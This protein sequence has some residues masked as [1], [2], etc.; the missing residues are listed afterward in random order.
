MAQHPESAPH[1]EPA[2]RT[3]PARATFSTEHFAREHRFDAWRGLLGLTHD[4]EGRPEDFHAHV[5]STAVG[6]MIA[7]EMSASPQG[8]ARSPHRVRRDSLDHV[9]L[10]LVSAEFGVE[11]GD[12]RFHVPVGVVTVNT[13]SQPFR[14]TVSPE[15]GSLILSLP[16]HLVAEVLP[17]PETFHG[18]ILRGGVGTLF[19]EHMRTLVRHAPSIVPVEAEGL[20]RAT[21]QLLASGLEPTRGRF[22]AARTGLRAAAVVRCKR[23]VERHLRSPDLTPEAICR[24]VGLSRSALYRLFAEDGGIATYIRSRRLQAA[25]DALAKPL[26]PRVSEVA[27]TYGFTNAATFSRAFRDAYGVNPTDSGALTDGA[28]HETD[29]FAAWMDAV[30]QAPHRRC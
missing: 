2:R 3:A 4:I 16:R 26:K 13:L 5:T 12:D 7:S 23:Y 17:E 24:A 30:S 6:P 8:V 19:R 11:R 14:R 20:A 15:H 9:V 28:G 18:Q 29:I 22:A 25:R 1:A 21:A 27:Y 10:H